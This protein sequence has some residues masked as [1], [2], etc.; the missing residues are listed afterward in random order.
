MG[1]CSNC[2]ECPIYR[3][4]EN[5]YVCCTLCGRILD[6]EIYCSRLTFA[7]DTGGQSTSNIIKILQHESSASN[8]RTLKKGRD[9]ISYIV[10][11]LNISGGDTIINNACAFYE[12]VVDTNF[13]KGCKIS[14]VAATCLYLAC[15]Q[16]KKDYLL[17]DF[18]DY[19]KINVYVLGAMFL[20]LCKTLNLLEHLIVLK[21]VDPSFFIHRF[22]KRLLGK[23]NDAVSE[24]ALRLVASM[25]RDWMQTGKKPNGLCGAALYISVHSHGLNYSKSDIVSAV[26]IC[27][28][29]LNRRLIEF[30]NN[31]S[32]QLS[33]YIDIG[34]GWVPRCVRS[35]LLQNEGSCDGN[36][37]PYVGHVEG[38]ASK[39]SKEPCSADSA[40]HELIDPSTFSEQ[41]G[42][43]DSED[44]GSDYLSFSDIDDAG[45]KQDNAKRQKVESDVGDPH[46]TPEKKD[47]HSDDPDDK[48]SDG[49]GSSENDNED[50]DYGDDEDYDYGDEDY[51]YDYDYEGEDYGYKDD[52]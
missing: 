25:K 40:G 20:Q 36:M 2:E 18:S 52:F 33:S 22:T 38:K 17:I 15:R 29:T 32:N 43:A 1:W 42:F 37:T 10:N 44:D 30:E 31:E 45:S 50:R 12:M 46:K 13:T 26:H 21:I 11:V 5:G 51:D 35:Q 7:K 49:S 39:E 14:H 28:A 48:D 16:S 6:Q 3:D 27:E 41:H 47:D 9:E 24:L 34:R 23:K 4:P 19:L 8:L